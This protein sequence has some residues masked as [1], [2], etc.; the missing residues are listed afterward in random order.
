VPPFG[1]CPVALRDFF[2]IRRGLS[3]LQIVKAK[4]FV[5][6]IF[7]AENIGWIIISSPAA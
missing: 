3:P 4:D 2:F 6:V 5:T 1:E 7:T